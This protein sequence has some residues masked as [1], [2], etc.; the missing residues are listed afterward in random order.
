MIV[1]VIPGVFGKLL[2]TKGDLPVFRVDVQNDGFDHFALLQN[3]G[4][5]IDLAGPGHIGDM[6]K[7][8]D[9]VFQ[10]HKGAV[11]GEVAD[12]AFDLAAD[13]ITLVDGFPRIAVR[14][15]ETEGDLLVV[16]VDGEDGRLDDVADLDEFRRMIDL[17]GPRE[18]GDVDEAFQA[19][20]QFH[21]SAV[22]QQIDD[23]A[24]HD[25]AGRILLIDIQPGVRGHLLDA[26]GNAFL[27]VI[28]ADDHNVDL[29]ADFQDLGR[30]IDAAPAHIGEVQKA[31]DA[32]QIDESAEVS[33]VLDNAFPDVAD[34]DLIEEGAALE[35]ALF[36]K[37]LAAGD[38]H[39][40]AFV[41]DFD[42]FDFDLL[43]DKVV[44]IL[45]VLERKLAGGQEGF[46]A[47]VDHKAAFDFPSDDTF[48]GLAVVAGRQ[49]GVPGTL[50][51]GFSLGEADVAV[52]VFLAD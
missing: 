15:T 5:M 40:L 51:V 14:L 27:I 24:F 52:L 46:D 8:V 38:H 48:D 13:W 32:G 31:I 47:D 12:H 35:G 42:D 20:F 7:A 10:F 11:N 50:T 6:D 33:D 2:Q 19:F 45:G 36:V 9:A 3:F 18:L 26:E 29:F 41:I 17:A 22:R 16:S 4:R 43:T 30:M 44:D 37:Q 21:E 49:S 34:L 25:G 23:F 1:D 28:D 39:V